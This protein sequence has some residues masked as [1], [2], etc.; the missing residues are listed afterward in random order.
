MSKRKRRVKAKKAKAKKVVVKKTRVAR[1]TVLQVK[2]P[3][4]HR[5][6]VLSDQA[7]GVVEVVPVKIEKRSWW[8][9]L[10]DW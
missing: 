10:F 4:G 3:K 7:K 2:L 6:A 9:S 1:G 5:P 8:D